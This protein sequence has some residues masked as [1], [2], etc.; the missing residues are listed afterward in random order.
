MLKLV[1]LATPPEV[2]TVSV[3]PDGAPLGKL[4][5][6]CIAKYSAAMPCGW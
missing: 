6:Y 1:E 2:V 3:T 4:P 5:A